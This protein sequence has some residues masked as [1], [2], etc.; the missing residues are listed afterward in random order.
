MVLYL[1]P[2]I[3][4]T[5]ANP[6]LHAPGCRRP[7]FT[8]SVERLQCKALEHARVLCVQQNHSGAQRMGE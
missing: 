7:V 6:L 8:H 1:E 4:Y 2:E 5:T 3:G